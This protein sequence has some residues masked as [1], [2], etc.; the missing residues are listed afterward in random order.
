MRR[1]DVLHDV[2][3][4]GHDVTGLGHETTRRGH[5]VTGLGHETTRRM[6]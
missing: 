4:R 5:D 6:S 3:R 2:T 1:H